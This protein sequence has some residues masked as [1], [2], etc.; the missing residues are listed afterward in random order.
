MILSACNRSWPRTRFPARALFW[1]ALAFLVAFAVKVP[2]F[3]LHGWLGDVFSE[4][5]TAMAMVVAGK[6][7]LYSILRFNLGLFPAQARQ[8]APWMIA[9]AV[10]WYSLRRIGRAGAKGYEAAAGLLHRQLP[11]LLHPGHLLASLFPAWMAL[12]TRY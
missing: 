4:A 8:V 5:P 6:L 9:L 7:G 10:D 2:V 3:P 12:S 1:A 11:Q